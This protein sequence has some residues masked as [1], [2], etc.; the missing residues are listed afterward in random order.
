MTALVIGEVLIDVV[1]VPG[2]P[3]ECTARGA[4]FN[5]PID[6][7]RLQIP[8]ALLSCANT[9]SCPDLPEAQLATFTYDFSEHER[10]GR[11]S[12]AANSVAPRG[13]PAAGVSLECVECVI[14]GI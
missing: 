4:P 8:T 2:Q 11:R 3:L 5:V 13:R 10:E 12:Q 9:G 14:A 7:E 1:G 6:L